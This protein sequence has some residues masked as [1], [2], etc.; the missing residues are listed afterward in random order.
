LQLKLAACQNYP[1]YEDFQPAT[2]GMILPRGYGADGML[3]GFSGDK[4]DAAGPDVE[5][6]P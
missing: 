2:T 6:L 4:R 3:C 1:V 5:G